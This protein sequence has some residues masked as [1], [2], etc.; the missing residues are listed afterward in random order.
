MTFKTISNMTCAV[1]GCTAQL[2]LS[3]DL[4]YDP[5]VTMGSPGTSIDI[6]LRAAAGLFGWN[7]DDPR[8]PRCASGFTPKERP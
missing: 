8:C 5:G 6:G 4:P 1:K 7:T 2:S 3:W